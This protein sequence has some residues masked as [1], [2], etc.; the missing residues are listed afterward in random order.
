MSF[1]GKIFMYHK[2]DWFWSKIHFRRWIILNLLSD[3][4]ETAFNQMSMNWPQSGCHFFEV[5]ENNCN[6][7]FWWISDISDFDTYDFASANFEFRNS[8]SFALV[9]NNESFFWVGHYETGIPESETRT[10]QTVWTRPR[11][12]DVTGP[13]FLTCPINLNASTLCWF[14]ENDSSRSLLP[15]DL[16]IKRSSSGALAFEY[17][18]N[19][20][21][22]LS[23]PSFIKLNCIAVIFNCSGVMFNYNEEMSGSDQGFI[24]QALSVLGPN[25]PVSEPLIPILLK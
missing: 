14:F 9:I 15:R 18:R 5:S 10:S 6:D 13:K 19:L 8:I 1:I 17:I 16:I 7:V 23:S 22:L 25:C 11:T 20:N 12:L 24:D 2:S 3:I 21:L 4:F